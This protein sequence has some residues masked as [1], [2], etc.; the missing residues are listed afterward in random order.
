MKRQAATRSSRLLRILT[1]TVLT[2]LAVTLG[3]VWFGSS[4]LRTT[5][6]GQLRYSDPSLVSSEGLRP[7]ASADS[8]LLQATPTAVAPD[9]MNQAV[10]MQ[11]VY[12]N[13]YKRVDPSVV[14]IDVVLRGNSDSP[15]SSGSGFVYDTEGHI[16]SNAHVV[17]DAREMF[18][19]FQGGY[20]AEATLVGVDDYSDLSVIKV[21]VKPERLIP[22]TLG[23]SSALEVGQSVIAIGNPF[24]L[25]SSMTTGI[26]SAT[27]RTL[28]S[29]LML[30]PRTRT[31]FENPAIIQVD[32]QI[33]PGN[34]GGPLLDLSGNVIGVNTAIRTETGTFQGIG[35]AVPV[36]TVKRV[37]PQI[38]RNGRVE[39]SW[40]GIESVSPL[41]SSGA[42]VTVG[43]LAEPFGLPVDY[44]VMIARVIADSPAEKAG[45]RGGT[46]DTTLRGVPITLGGD[47]IVAVNGEKVRDFDALITYL[48]S[49]TGPGDLIT[50]T[51][52][53]GERTFDVDVTLEARPS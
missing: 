4:P 1:A 24:G 18:V 21:D 25:L 29:A 15:D 27:G 35:F 16:I 36:N 9:V 31:P 34:S 5:S 50:L 30:R 37:V 12:V 22:V 33:N 8:A 6:A 40:L 23:D 52:Y 14:N 38:I 10:A 32:A 44:G 28:N 13:M 11:Q 49:N 42:E 46:R 43:A 26:I 39:Y 41:L 51:I 48:V 17:Q 3:V 47:I 20:V 45:L 2:V 19:T 53:R 7:A